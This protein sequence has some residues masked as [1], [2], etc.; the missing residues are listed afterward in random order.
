MAILCF[1]VKGANGTLQFDYRK[2]IIW[3]GNLSTQNSPKPLSAPGGSVQLASGVAPGPVC[4]KLAIAVSVAGS[5]SI[6]T[7]DGTTTTFTTMP[8]GFFEIDCQFV[9]A[10]WAATATAV[11]FYRIDG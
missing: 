11:G 8:I 2:R 7:L 3:M 1:R 9:S 4:H 6:T 5:L 10:S